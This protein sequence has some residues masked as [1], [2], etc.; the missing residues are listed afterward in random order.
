MALALSSSLLEQQKE[1]QAECGPSHSAATPLLKWKPNAAKGRVKKKKMAAPRPPP[2]L[3]VQDAETAL[4]RL[5]ERVSTLLL[6]RRAP[7]PPTPTRCPSS[8]PAWTGA[9]PLW[10]KSA[11]Q[12]GGS[13]SLSDFYAAE[14]QHLFMT[15]ELAKPDEVLPT[16][17]D[18]SESSVPPSCSQ[19]ASSAPSTPHT[20]EL[21]V[22]SQALRDLMELAEDGMTLTQYGYADKAKRLSGFIQEEE[23]ER[24]AEPSVDATS[25]RAT[26]RPDEPGPDEDEGGYES[27]ALSRLSSDLSSMVNNPQL[28]DVQLQVDSGEV[29]FAH[30][31]M[32]YARCPLLAE[33]VHES[34]FGVQEEGV[35][36]AQRVLLSDVPGQAVLALLRYLY[37]SR[38]SVDASLQPHVLELASRFDLQELEQLCRLRAD[39]AA[40]TAADDQKEHVCNRTDQAFAELLRSMWNE[41]GEEEEEDEEAAGGDGGGRSEEGRREDEVAAGDGEIREEQVNEEE[42]EEIYEFAATQRQKEER[43]ST[44]EEEE[45]DD[46]EDAAFTDLKPKVQTE[47]DPSLD[48][49]YSRLFSQSWGVYHEGDVSCEPGMPPLSQHPPPPPQQAA[50]GHPGRTLLQSSASVVDEPPLNLPVPGLS[51]PRQD[52]GDGG[53]GAAE[54]TGVS[55]RRDTPGPRSARL[56]LPPKPPAAKAEP[57]LIVLSDSSEEMEANQ[58]YTGIKSSPNPSPKE[59][60]SP[61]DPAGCSPELSWLI[62]STPDQSPPVANTRAASTQTIN[63]VLRTQLFTSA[64]SPPPA[65]PL[66][67]NRQASGGPPKLDAAGGGSRLDPSRNL[68]LDASPET[69]RDRSENG[70]ITVGRRTPVQPC[71]STPLHAQLRQPPVPPTA[72]PLT[73]DPEKQMKRRTSSGS[74]KETESGSFHLPPVSDSSD[75]PSSSFQMKVTKSDLQRGP[76]STG[77]GDEVEGV[78]RCN[79]SMKEVGFVPEARESSFQQSFLDE[80]PIAFNDSWGLDVCAEANP[81]CFSLRL[82]DSSP[83]GRRGSFSSASKPPPASHNGV[84]SPAPHPGSST[85]VEIDNGLLDSKIWDSWEEEEE[86]LPLAQRVNPAAHLTTPISSKRR[87]RRSVVPITPMPH[88]SDMD[89]PELKNKLS[90]FGV[91]PLPKRQMVLKLKE[92][93]QYTHQLASSDSEGEEAARAKA[94]P[95]GG[96]SCTQT[97]Q[98]RE[99]RAPASTAQTD[100]AEV[101]DML[102]ASQGSNTSSTAGSEESERS[103]PELVLSSDGDS[104]SDVSCSQA[105][106][107][108]QDRLQ[109]VRSFILSDPDLYGRILQ[110]QPLVLSQLQQQLKAAGIRLGAAKLV[111][112]LDSQ[113]ITFTTAKAGR[114]AAGRGKKPGRAARGG[115]R[116][117]AAE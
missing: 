53:G 61:G 27:V 95:I 14:L 103:N 117:N 17:N 39:N 69:R 68:R 67:N 52:D 66:K 26:R 47:P 60:V 84:Q 44:V 19:T 51:P 65:S 86:G 8:L 102:S 72:S 38:C 46:E 79:D 108:L 34:G 35:P 90:S 83:S 37:T 88:Y 7:S 20:G 48:R 28:S 43:E 114:P 58:S 3:L 115:G 54:T 55:L 32:V 96:A 74:S 59:S 71:S 105:A 4:A 22:G 70:D 31:F 30:S 78:G 25:S 110:Y 10:L 13:T 16:T 45:D 57:E 21:N 106:S 112:Y 97:G 89:T 82:E 100:Q 75:P 15:V 40:V 113:C 33:M 73:V 18:K 111:D 41:E 116:K 107:R 5:Q 29:Y 93:H 42:L 9:A 36:A 62:P 77:G 85:A 94:A 63:G 23:P 12:D 80:P 92:I 109:A 24:R 101:A 11:L 87:Q 6:R 56:P 49:S 64:D 50:S 76:E 99:P 1:Q 81:G 98:F 2:L 104:D 91:R